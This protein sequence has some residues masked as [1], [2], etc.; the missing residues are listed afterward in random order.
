MWFNEHIDIP[1]ELGT[2]QSQAPLCPAP[3]CVPALSMQPVLPL[4]LPS[5][6]WVEARRNAFTPVSSVTFTNLFLNNLWNLFFFF[7]KCILPVI[8]MVLKPTEHYSV[9]F[10]FSGTMKVY[11]STERALLF[12][13][14]NEV[15]DCSWRSHS[16]KES[17]AKPWMLPSVVLSPKSSEKSQKG[18]FPKRISKASNRC[19]QYNRENS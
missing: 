12:W 11:F 17:K 19:L 3:Q 7:F 8:C 14:W 6:K 15:R 4:N 5:D 1:F 9:A 16:Q 10:I 18:S 2:L 13:A